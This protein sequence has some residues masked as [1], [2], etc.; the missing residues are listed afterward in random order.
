MRR[1]FRAGI[2]VLILLPASVSAATLLAVM[3]RAA[4]LRLYRATQAWLMQRWCRVIARVVGLHVAVSGEPCGEP[5]LV[6]CNHKS[7]I[8]IIVLGATLNGAFVSK[9][10]IADWPLVGFFA[11]SGGRTLFINRGELRSFQ[12]LGGDLIGR[13]RDGE[14][15]IFF[16][17]GTVSGPEPLLRFKPRLFAAAQAAR[18]AVQPVALSY[19][20]GDGAALAPMRMEEGFGPHCMRFLRARRTEV[21]LEFLPP[22]ETAGSDV[23]TLAR[24]VHEHVRNAITELSHKL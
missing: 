20:G 15:V 6:A 16:P 1:V 2:V 17:E 24:T 18:C 9:A 21:L 19:V 22:I 11:R 5:V 7:W 13:L 12:D 4:P 3:S 10:E 14:R 8:D 23:R